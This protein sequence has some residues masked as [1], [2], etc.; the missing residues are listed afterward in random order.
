MTNG[1]EEIVYSRLRLGH[2]GLNATLKLVGK[3]N[4]LCT[5]CQTQEDVKHLN[6]GDIQ[7]AETKM[8]RNGW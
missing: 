1:K 3:W 7:W 2:T 8:A 4:A 6:V 5:E